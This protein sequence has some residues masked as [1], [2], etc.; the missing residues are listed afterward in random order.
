MS[1]TL[2][3]LTATLASSW[4]SPSSISGASGA[5]LPARVGH[6]HGLLRDRGGCE[7]IAAAAGWNEALYKTW[8]LTGAVLTAGWLGLGTALLLSKTRFGYAVAISIFL[9]GCSRC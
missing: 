6:R 8:Y 2:P 1:V 4:P 9:A 5:G 7:A 3:A